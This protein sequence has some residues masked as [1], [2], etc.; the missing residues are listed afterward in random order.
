MT[1]LRIA[2]I[3][4]GRFHGFDLARELLRLGHDVH[5]F[6]NYPAF[7]AARFGIP[8]RRVRSFV[9]HGIT[10]RMAWKL[11]PGGL[12]GTIER[13]ANSIFSRWAARQIL[14]EPWNAVIAFSG[15][16]EEAFRGLEGRDTLRVL[17]R[18]SAHIVTQRRILDEEESRIGKRIDKPS[19]WIVARERREYC[20]ADIIHVLSSFAYQSFVDEGVD[21]R[22]LF[23]LTLGVNTRQFRGSP[24]IIE[25]RCRRI[26]AG[27]PL[28]VLNVGTFSY[29]KGIA[30]LANVILRLDASRFRFRFVGPVAHEARGL[31]QELDGKA[32]FRAKR[33]QRDLPREYEWGDIFL[34]ATVQDGFA[35][36]LTQGLAAGLPLLTTSNCAGPDLVRQGETG[37]IVPIRS[38]EAIIERLQWLNGHRSILERA[39]R[40]V[41][42]QETPFDWAKTGKQAQAN[43]LQMIG[44]V[45]HVTGGQPH[46][47]AAERL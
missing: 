31:R 47:A 2:V 32:E 10:S 3:V 20:L 43:M 21:P 19:D 45:R 25:E 17:Q 37:W 24:A 26:L 27:E 18:G 30:D 4:H 6:T 33:P 11:F 22:K 41:F 29:Q 42:A 1:R 13:V 23:L 16:A 5:L 36:V 40:Q 28:R 12:D 8:A 7:Q 34:L 46:A 35:A 14:A 15:V 39:V 9:V 38:P 44:K